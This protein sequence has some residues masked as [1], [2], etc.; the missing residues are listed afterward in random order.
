M[1]MTQATEAYRPEDLEASLPFS[2]EYLVIF[3]NADSSLEI[4]E[5]LFMLIRVTRAVTEKNPSNGT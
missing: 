2:R 1:G 4:D 5:M 3:K